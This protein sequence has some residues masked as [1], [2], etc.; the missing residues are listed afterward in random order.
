[1]SYVS[2]W[3]TNISGFIFGFFIPPI[4][5]HMVLSQRLNVFHLKTTD[6]QVTMRGNFSFT[7]PPLSPF[8]YLSTPLL[9]TP[10][11]AII[12]SSSSIFPL[13]WKW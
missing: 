3:R 4:M 2:F 12:I 13:S 11:P 7:G 1:M 10:L 5:K 6:P 8:R 9:D